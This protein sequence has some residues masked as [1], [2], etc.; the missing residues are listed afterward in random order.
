MIGAGQ[1]TVSGRDTS[2]E[3]LRKSVEFICDIYKKEGALGLI[4]QQFGKARDSRGLPNMIN[5]IVVPLRGDPDRTKKAVKRFLDIA[6]IPDSYPLGDRINARANWYFV[7]YTPATKNLDNVFNSVKIGDFKGHRKHIL[8]FDM[9]IK[10]NISE[11]VFSVMTPDEKKQFILKHT[12]QYEKLLETDPVY[13]MATGNGF[14]IGYYAKN[15]EFGSKKWSVCQNVYKGVYEKYL[16]KLRSLTSWRFDVKCSSINRIDRV[17]FTYNLKSDKVED[18]VFSEMLYTN[19]DAG[20]EFAASF[21]EAVATPE[22]NRMVVEDAGRAS[23]MYSVLP[24]LKD[25]NPYVYKFLTEKLSFRKVFEYFGVT[26]DLAFPMS[27]SDIEGFRTCFSPFRKSIMGVHVSNEERLP[28]FR[29]DENTKKF[30]DFGVVPHTDSSF[31][32]AAGLAYALHKFRETE[33]EW[34]DRINP[35]EAIK[36]VMQIMTGSTVEQ[37]QAGLTQFVR[38]DKGEVVADFNSI[39]RVILNILVSKYEMVFNRVQKQSFFRNRRGDDEFKPFPWECQEFSAKEKTTSARLLL[40]LAGISDPKGPVLSTAKHLVDVIIDPNSV[41]LKN[42]GLGAYFEIDAV[43]DVIF[44]VIDMDNP[45]VRFSDGVFYHFK[46][47]DT[48]DFYEGYAYDVSVDFESIKQHPK[49]EMFESLLTTLVGPEG[50]PERMVFKYILAQ[51]WFPAHGDSR[52]LVIK[53]YGKNGKSTLAEVLSE[54]LPKGITYN[55]NIETLT[56]TNTSETASR[57]EFLGKHLVIVGDVSEHKLSLK[58]KNFISGDRGGVTAKLLFKNPI[59]FK[60][61]ATLLLMTNSFP[62]IVDDISAFLRRFL[63]IESKARVLKPILGMATQIVEY[64]QSYVWRYIIN[65]VEYFREHHNFTFPEDADWAEQVRV[66][67]KRNLINQLPTGELALCIGYSPG[68]VI[69]VRHL[70]EFHAEY[71]DIIGSRKM[72]LKGFSEKIASIIENDNDIYGTDWKEHFEAVG[73]DEG[74]IVLYKNGQ[75]EYI[76]NADFSRPIVGGSV[77]QKLVQGLDSIISLKSSVQDIKLQS[78][79]YPHESSSEIIMKLKAW[80]DTYGKSVESGK[81]VQL[82]SKT[83]PYVPSPKKDDDASDRDASVKKASEP[84]L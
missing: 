36:L 2:K 54:V 21:G 82:Q 7:E 61:A 75:A 66:P 29:F 67:M 15:L 56:T 14:H 59:K 44:P 79:M 19:Y 18:A 77:P 12:E 57:I 30:W 35:G 72:S 68:R 41:R 28:S 53:G 23:S 65:A 63:V 3:T 74:F 17:P 38:N 83:L 16:S 78:T 6:V 31:G 58:L 43:N 22:I 70:Y 32:D 20:Y 34:P 47:G 37:I 25:A 27:D 45:V 55:C 24:H 4:F 39:S 8:Y 71:S 51:M 50:S 49:G 81:V 76:I 40:N 64:E 11:E 52:A 33:G 26:G 10:Y 42:N 84:L 13:V 1:A 80:R 48:T 46:T 62:K 9:D 60:N 69:S 5:K 73:M